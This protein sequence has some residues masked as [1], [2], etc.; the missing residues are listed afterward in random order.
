MVAN[1]SAF[2]GL[3][4]VSCLITPTRAPDDLNGSDASV[5]DS[6]GHV[7]S[8]HHMFDCWCRHGHAIA[9]RCAQCSAGTRERAWNMPVL[10]ASY[11]HHRLTHALAVHVVVGGMFFFHTCHTVGSPLIC[12]LPSSHVRQATAYSARACAGWLSRA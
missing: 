6:L 5:W 12:I 4:C 9:L 10:H 2:H 7:V 8:A 1:I 11:S 3:C